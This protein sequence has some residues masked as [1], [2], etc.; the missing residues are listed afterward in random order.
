MVFTD[1]ALYT[2][3]IMFIKHAASV[4]ALSFEGGHE[5]IWQEEEVRVI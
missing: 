1:Q 5:L 4:Q 3:Y 2:M